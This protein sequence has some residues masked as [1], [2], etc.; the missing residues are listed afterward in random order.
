[1]SKTIKTIM[2]LIIAIV[3]GV[4]WFGYMLLWWGANLPINAIALAICGF[5]AWMSLKAVFK[6]LDRLLKLD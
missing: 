2:P 6:M 4:F 5:A 1:M 3:L